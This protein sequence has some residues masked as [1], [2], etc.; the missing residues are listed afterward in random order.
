MITNIEGVK[1]NKSIK[2]YVQGH[3]GKGYVNFIR[4]NLKQIEQVILLR[5][6]NPVLITVTINKLIEIYK[7]KQIEIIKSIDSTELIDGLIVRELSVAILN[8]RIYEAG[9][10]ATTTITI[11]DH[12][13]SVNL[14]EIN[15]ES[16]TY[17]KAYEHFAKGLEI[18]EQLEKVYIAKMDFKK[19]DKII[20]DLIQQLFSQVKK[21]NRH[22]MIYERLFGTNT[23]D[24]IVNEIPSLINPLRKNI[25]ILGRAG[26]GK[27]YL[28]NRI[29]EKCIELG[30]DVEI[31]R[32]SLDPNSIDMLI[33]RQL[34][35]CIHDNTSPHVVPTND[36]QVNIIDM[37]KETVD[38]TIEITEDD[39]IKRLT[40]QYK[41]QMQTGLYYLKAQQIELS[42]A[43]KE[44]NESD[45]THIIK[46]VLKNC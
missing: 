45:F 6:K 17:E 27:S 40:Q 7:D 9:P 35:V 30:L 24:G 22:S 15:R 44:T 14:P 4:S 2:Y 29:R 42:Q 23:P 39:T 10:E 18:H 32:C 26:T 19:A 3:T 25:F 36:E 43:I 28:M 5:A 16:K 46:N 11:P 38:Q 41:K 34:S 21:Q 13:T 1:V 12:I 37:Y 33:I 8:E 20:A 31:Y